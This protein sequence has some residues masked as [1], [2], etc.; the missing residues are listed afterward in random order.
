MATVDLSTA[1]IPC[2]SCTGGDWVFVREGGDLCRPELKRTFKL[3]RCSSCGHVVQ[4]PQP[5]GQ[6]LFAAYSVSDGYAAYKAAWNEPRW[7]IWKLKRI[8]TMRRRMAWIRRYG[9]GTEMLEVGCGAGDFMVAA[10]RA[11]WKMKAVEYNSNMVKMIVA[12]RGYD[13]RVGELAPGLWEEGRFDMVAF[14][15][16]LEHV[17]DPLRDLSIAAAYLRPGGKV[18]VNIPTR[19]SAEHGLWFGQYWAILDLPRH[20]NF[21]YEA[22]LSRLCAKAGL[23]LIVYKTPFIQSAW[24]YYMSAWIWANRSGKKILGWLRF[25]AL[26]IAITLIMPYVAL[27]SVRKRGMEATAVAVKR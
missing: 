22:T 16:V 26:V 10:D 17:P 3:T 19:E 12:K 11:G 9:A 21:Y 13:I 1:S 5:D 8:W 20:L 6:A 15:N 24:S 27:E 14:W 7:P 23:D 2:P 4:N 18:I 25:L